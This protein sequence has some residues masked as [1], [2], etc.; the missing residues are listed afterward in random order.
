VDAWTRTEAPRSFFPESLFEYIDGAAES[1]LSY[2]FREL[3]VVDLE[4]KGTEA[5]LTLEIYDMGSPVNAFG[6]LARSATRRTGPSPS[7][8]WVTSRARP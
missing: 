6:I 7:A 8:N 5:T 3:L 1:Y 2:D 4:K